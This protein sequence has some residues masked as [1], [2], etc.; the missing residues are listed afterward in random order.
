MTLKK[1]TSIE[2]FLN[3]KE[4]FDGFKIQ[5]AH[6]E[7]LSKTIEEQQGIQFDGYGEKVKQIANQID[8]LNQ[9]VEEM[10][11][12]ISLLIKKEVK[13]EVD[14]HLDINR[15]QGK[16]DTP[17]FVTNE[18]YKIP[19]EIPQ[20]KEPFLL[21]NNSPSYMQL[22]KLAG[23]ARNTKPDAFIEK[24]VASKPVTQNPPEER[25]F[26]H[27]YFQSTSTHPSHMYNGLYKN[28]SNTSSFHFKNESSVQEIPIYKNEPTENPLI[29]LG[30]KA[31]NSIVQ[32]VDKVVGINSIAEEMVDSTAPIVEDRE[33]SI[34]AAEKIEPSTAQIIDKME[35]TNTTAN[36]NNI[37]VAPIV[38]DVKSI[39]SI[40]EKINISA[41]LKANEVKI[42]NPIIEETDQS[43]A[44]I[45][46]EVAC[47]DAVVEEI[48]EVSL[49]FPIE[50]I[51]VQTESSEINGI[52]EE[53]LNDLNET[54]PEEHK[55]E[56]FSSFFNLF[57][58]RS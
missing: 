54:V 15:T 9:T 37:S 27:Q 26:N 10:N 57:R 4:E 14:E 50:K 43:A 29:D 33:N 11:Q 40:S 5:I 24:P 30:S 49:E 17:L 36:E 56:G 13:V 47:I 35:S 39:D 12:E 2:E 42:I 19:E 16:M 22:Q 8:I 52:Q 23:L 31:S 3:K 21:T 48:N 7:G 38:D 32:T 44:P 41:D 18:V 6:L 51:S 58:R 34:T 53:P 55:K 1:G 45:D 28:I 20:V 46:E 25:H